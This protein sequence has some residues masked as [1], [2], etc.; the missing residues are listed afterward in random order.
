LVLL[1]EILGGIGG[2]GPCG[3]AGLGVFLDDPNQSL[4]VAERER[5]QQDGIHYSEDRDVCANA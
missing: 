2:I 4:W 5:P 3:F 1:L